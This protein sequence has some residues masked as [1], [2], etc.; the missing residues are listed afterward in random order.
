[1]NDN[2]NPAVGALPGWRGTD[3]DGGTWVRR[4]DEC[5][6]SARWLEAATN[7][8]VHYRTQ[9]EAEAAGLEPLYMVQLPDPLPAPLDPD[10]PEHGTPAGMRWAA[11]EIGG[12]LDGLEGEFSVYE[13]R[14]ELRAAA[15]R[16][17]AAE[18]E[19]MNVG[20]AR[21]PRFARLRAAE[22]EIPAAP[23]SL[24]PGNPEHPEVVTAGDLRWFAGVLHSRAGNWGCLDASH[25]VVAA[26]RAYADRL[27]RERAEAEQDASDRQLIEGSIREAIPAIGARTYEQAA[28]FEAVAEAVLRAER[29]RQEAGQ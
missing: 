26:I 16:M 29:A 18:V 13:L 3:P 12:M 19:D 23:A 17:E 25:P 20:L 24:D 6:P 14:D 10:N 15:D 5:R 9:E 11:D 22:A 4:P 2:S 21:N 7:G 27:D 1:M 8:D 28:E